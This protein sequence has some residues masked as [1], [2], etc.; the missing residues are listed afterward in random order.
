[1]TKHAK[2]AIKHD[3]SRNVSRLK[4]IQPWSQ[5]GGRISS[6]ADASRSQRKHPIGSQKYTRQVIMLM[7][8]AQ[9]ITYLP[10]LNLELNLP[11]LQRIT[12]PTSTRKSLMSGLPRRLR[13][14]CSTL[15]V[16]YLDWTASRSWALK[17][18]QQGS[19]L[20]PANSVRP[21]LYRSGSWKKPFSLSATSMSFTCFQILS[22]HT[23]DVI[24]RK[25]QYLMYFQI[26]LMRSPMARLRCY[27]YLI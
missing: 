3:G 16:K 5:S 9:L 25:Q 7:Y 17:M 27:L 1:M 20:R 12:T 19:E 2:H 21:T 13:Y 24:Q 4:K 18:L 23:D 8:G 10:R 6:Q 26:S 15:K 14:C 11:F 22:R